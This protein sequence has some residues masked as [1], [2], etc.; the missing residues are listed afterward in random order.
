[1]CVNLLPRRWKQN[2]PSLLSQISLTGM[3]QIRTID[4]RSMLWNQRFKLYTC[5]Y[6]ESKK[7]LLCLD[8][9]NTFR[10]KRTRWECFQIVPK[11]LAIHF[12][13]G[14]FAFNS[15]GSTARILLMQ[16]GNL[17]NGLLVQSHF[18]ND[19]THLLLPFTPSQL[20]PPSV[21]RSFYKI[22]HNH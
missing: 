12:Q 4:T 15:Y 20:R 9:Q 3:I 11:I 21:N 16:H 19:K 2:I 5:T 10:S 1:M 7:V 13:Q 18:N 14:Y 8:I 17:D 6:Y 22:Q